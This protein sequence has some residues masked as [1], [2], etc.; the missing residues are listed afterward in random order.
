A[1]VSCKAVSVAGAGVSSTT[2]VAGGAAVPWTAVAAGDANVSCTAI[3]ATAG[4]GVCSAAIVADVVA[5]LSET[6]NTA[7]PAETN[8]NSRKPITNL[9]MRSPRAIEQSLLRLLKFSL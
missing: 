2:E 7:V 6:V 1:R 8:S 5:S 9:S 4:A 3:V